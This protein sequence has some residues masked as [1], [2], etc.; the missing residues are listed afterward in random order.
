MSGV[1]Y[2]NYLFINWVVI[3]DAETCADAWPGRKM[4]IPTEPTPVVSDNGLPPATGDPGADARRRTVYRFAFRRQCTW[5]GDDITGNIY[6]FNDRPY[7]CAPHRQ[8]AF[9]VVHKVATDES[10][11]SQCPD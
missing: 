2:Y 6:M 10:C 7:C 3:R 9:I 4:T 5:C 8:S 1:S 11:A